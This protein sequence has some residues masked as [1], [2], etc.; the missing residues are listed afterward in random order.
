MVVDLRLFQ[1]FLRAGQMATL[2]NLRTACL[3]NAA[4]VL[5]K[6]VRRFLAQSGYRRQQ[7]A[8]RKIQCLVRGRA[9]TITLVLYAVTIIILKTENL[10][11]GSF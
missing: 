5:Q 9:W 11:P 8:A 6:Y 7:K 3:N 1:V 10:T 4:I 2:E